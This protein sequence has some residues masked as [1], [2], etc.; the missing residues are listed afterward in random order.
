MPSYGVDNDSRY[1]LTCLL[2]NMLRIICRSPLHLCDQTAEPD[3]LRK[4][5]S[6]PGLSTSLCLLTVDAVWSTTPNS[7]V[8]GI[9]IVMDGVLELWGQTNPSFLELL[10]P[11]HKVSS[12]HTWK[13]LVWA[14]R[15][16]GLQ[17]VMTERAWQGEPMVETPSMMVYHDQTVVPQ[18]GPS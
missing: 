3:Q 13:A 14:H 12:Q 10:L 11:L 8:R 9:S 17:C 6:K 7:C 2:C 16:R 4:H 18:L 5:D 1:F 15:F